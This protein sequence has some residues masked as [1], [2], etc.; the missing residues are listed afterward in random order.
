MKGSKYL[1]ALA[2]V[3]LAAQPAAA[4]DHFRSAH[5]HFTGAFAGA[6]LKLAV[7]RNRKRAPSVQLGVGISQTL[8]YSG[9]AAAVH[10]PSIELRLTSAAKPYLF[11]AGQNPSSAGQRLGFTA[12]TALL[13]VGGL[14]AGALL[15]AGAS[16]D[17]ESELE[18]R[19]CFLPERELC[20]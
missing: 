14:A 15:V 13:V 6:T 3:A 17:E 4:V 19:Q 11:A 8:H 18:R 1:V 20:R 5:P 16:S 10:I 9:S 12:G 7:N 2:A